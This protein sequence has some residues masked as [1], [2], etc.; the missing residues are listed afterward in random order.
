M[1]SSV[2]R[3]RICPPDFE[4]FREFE[5]RLAGK[6]YFWRAPIFWQISGG[7]DQFCTGSFLSGGSGGILA[8]L[9]SLLAKS[10]FV[11]THSCIKNKN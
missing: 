10:N 6:K 3:W 9:E 4:N 5:R 2:A 1:W 7:F 11:I 8:V